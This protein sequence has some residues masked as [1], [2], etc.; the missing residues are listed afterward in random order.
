MQVRLQHSLQVTDG[1][2]DVLSN[3]DAA[4]LV[5]DHLAEEADSRGLGREIRAFDPNIDIERSVG[6]RG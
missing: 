3:D 5:C 4:Q 6:F 1:I 2:S